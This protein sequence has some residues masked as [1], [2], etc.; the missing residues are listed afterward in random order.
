MAPAERPISTDE[1][2]AHVDGRLD[3]DRRQE[4]ERYLDLQPE[5]ALRVS[6][7]RAQRDAL[8][9]AFASSATT[10]IPPELNLDRLLEAR[11]QQRPGW[12][13]W[14]VAAVVVLCL[15][16]GGASGWYLGAS[17]APTLIQ[18][19]VS[20]LQQEAMASHAVY[21]ADRRHP[22]EVAATEKD[23]LSQ[24]LSNRLR[25]NVVPPDLSTLG[26]RLLGGRLLATEHGGAAAL[27]VYDDADGNR[28]TVLLRPMAPELHAALLDLA[29][30]SLNG[31][32]WIAG[33]MGYAV[34]ASA[35]DQTLDR[36]ANH[37][38]RQANDPG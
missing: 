30:G 31:C 24:W 20:L 36:I 34:V 23:H 27:F 35:P 37:I 14:Q 19:A 32:T 17:P 3:A 25:R 38:S 29:Q 12:A 1:L 13:W 10:P 2:H 22:I 33:G 21:A 9:S 15:G 8:R 16:L 6:A 4:I 26:Y 18:Q 7:Y 11:L 28:L 5:L